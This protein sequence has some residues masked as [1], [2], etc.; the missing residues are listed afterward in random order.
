M[1]CPGECLDSLTKIRATFREELI[2]Q[3]EDCLTGVMVAGVKVVVDPI[4]LR[5][6]SE[7][8][9]KKVVETLDNFVERLERDAAGHET[10]APGDILPHMP[11]LEPGVRARKSFERPSTSTSRPS[12]SRPTTPVPQYPYPS[13]NNINQSTSSLSTPWQPSFDSNSHDETSLQ[14]VMRKIPGNISRMFAPETRSYNPA[15]PVWEPTLVQST[16]SKVQGPS[17]ILQ[18]QR[19][20]IA[21]EFAAIPIESCEDTLQVQQ[22]QYMHSA[23]L[24]QLPW[25]SQSGSKNNISRSSSVG[26]SWRGLTP[27]PL[28]DMDESTKWAS[29]PVLMPRKVEHLSRPR[30]RRIRSEPALTFSTPTPRF[31]RAGSRSPAPS[32]N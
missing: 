8:T 30:E 32:C 17:S 11:L 3:L 26:G 20:A 23:P 13:N 24:L 10:T 18:E 25:G 16:V 2:H 5:V 15:L 27:P 9:R 19:E 12:T 7:M 6:V 22:P 1:Y 21:R 14:A 4:K 31:G 29:D 28:D